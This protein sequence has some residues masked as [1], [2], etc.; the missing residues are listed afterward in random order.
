MLNDTLMFLSKA[1][2]QLHFMLNRRKKNQIVTLIFCFLLNL[3]F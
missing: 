1:N 2:T 3:F